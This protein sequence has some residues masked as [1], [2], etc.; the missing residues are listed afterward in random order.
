MSRFI[1]IEA[2]LTRIVVRVCLLTSVLLG[3]LPITNAGELSRKALQMHLPAPLLAQEK[4]ADIAAWPITDASRNDGQPVGYAFESVDFAPIP[5]YEGTPVNLLVVVDKLGNFVDVEVLEQHEPM[6]VFSGLG[7]GPLREF[8]KQYIG[9]NLAREILIASG[10]DSNQKLTIAGGGQRPVIDGISKAT[11]TVRIVHKS[12]LSSAL[13]VAR[14]KLG[15]AGREPNRAPAIAR[16]DLFE[17]L[18]FAQLLQQGM[19]GHLLA[20][21]A[22]VD[23][24]FAGTEWAD[25]GG[26][27]QKGDDTPAV[28]LYFAYLNA[29]S[30]GR[31]LLGDEAYRELLTKLEVGQTALWI[32][33][34]GSYSITD[35]RFVPGGE[36]QRLAL[37]QDGLPLEIHDLIFDMPTVP[38]APHFEMARIFT[39]FSESGLDPGKPLDLSILITRAKGMVIPRIM[40]QPLHLKYVPPARLFSYPPS[41]SPAPEWLAAWR[42]RTWDIGIISASLIALAVILSKPR[43]FAANPRRMQAVRITFLAFTLVFLGWYVQGQLSIVQITGAIKSLVA[44]RGLEIFLYDPI[45]LMVIVFT[46][47]TFF[48]WGR[49]AFCGWLCPFGALQEFVAMAARRLGLPQYQPPTKISVY[50]PYLRY[51]LLLLLCTVSLVA[52]RASEALVEVEPFKTAITVGFDRSWPFIAYALLL[53][54]V[55]AFYFKFFCRV[56][57]PLGAAMTLGGKLRRLDWVLRRRECGKPCQTCRARC[58]YD[59]IDRDG[60]I[61]YDHCFQCLDCVGVYHD[62]DRCAPLLLYKRKGKT[63]PLRILN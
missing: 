25:V 23:A 44:G 33:S 9:L 31:S 51:G 24:L 22:E 45:S 2:R 18:D 30:I 40:E 17:R 50:F 55:G 3:F 60:S 56:L 16:S 46:L 14:T 58:D 20:S 10:S 42:A 1:P 19:V 61:H 59:A 53:L 5:G 7:E 37:S 57:C 28:D 21:S 27:G 34:A 4:L 52:P 8:V 12:I 11:A 35:E 43:M 6:F 26:D 47:L 63:I 32:A 38:Q 29:P 15:L 36:P 48:L 62:T 54:I 39:V 41:P 13:T 49:G